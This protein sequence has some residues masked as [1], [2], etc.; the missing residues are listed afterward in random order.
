[1]KKEKKKSRGACYE[2]SG[3]AVKTMCVHQIFARQN[4]SLGSLNSTQRGECLRLSSSINQKLNV[5]QI[6]LYLR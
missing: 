6:Q 3:W 2:K 5:M 1:M 4:G